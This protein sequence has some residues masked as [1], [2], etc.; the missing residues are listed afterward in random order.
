M[1][2]ND[3]EVVATIGFG[4]EELDFYM[5]WAHGD[6]DIGKH[7]KGPVLELTGVHTKYSE[8]AL[9]LFKEFIKQ[10]EVFLERLKKHYKMF[11]EA[12]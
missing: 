8:R 3:E 2:Y 10:D 12:L 4:W 7:M 5:K 6:K 11:K 9:I 1:I